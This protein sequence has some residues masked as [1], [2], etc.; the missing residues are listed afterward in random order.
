MPAPQL[1]LAEQD[2]FLAEAVTRDEPRL[3]SFIRSRVLSTSDT[4]D[5]LQD[6]FYELLQA[7]RL[8]QPVGAGVGLAFPG[9]AQPALRTSFAARSRHPSTN[10]SPATRTMLRRS[11]TCFRLPMPA[12]RPLFARNQLLDALDD[13]LDELP[14]TQRDTFIAHEFLGQSFQQISAETGTP[15]NTLLSHKRKAVLALRRRLEQLNQ[16]YSAQ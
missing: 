1:T 16:T 3:R 12:P 7:Y 14:A 15:I 13:T 9:R 6:V 11:K 5:I 4:E 2:H 8:M 10:P